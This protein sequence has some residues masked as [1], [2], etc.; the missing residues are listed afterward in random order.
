MITACLITIAWCAPM[1]LGAS[2]AITVV[3]S[4]RFCLKAVLTFAKII[5]EAGD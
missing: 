5:A 4:V 2:V 3:A 1:P